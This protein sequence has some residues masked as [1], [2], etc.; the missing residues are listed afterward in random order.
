METKNVNKVS[1]HYKI[2]NYVKNR[3]QEFV[4]YCKSNS[5]KGN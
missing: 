1:A 3:A 4:K 5:N 2:V